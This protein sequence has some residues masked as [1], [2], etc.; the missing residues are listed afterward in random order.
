LNAKLADSKIFIVGSGAIGCELLKNLAMMGVG[1]SSTGSIHITDMDRIEK[2]NLNRQFL[3]GYQDIGKYKS[4]AVVGAI[5]RINPGVNIIAQQNK[6]GHETLSIYNEK[7]MRELTCVLTALDNIQARIFV[8]NLCIDSTIPLIDSGTLGTKGNVQTIIPHMTQTYGSTNDPAEQ[9]IPLC[10][11]KSFPYMIEHTIQ[12][13]RDL[14]EGLYIKAP[15]NYMRYV[16]SPQSIKSINPSELKEVIDDIIFVSENL[17]C[18]V[19]ECVE[20]AYKMWHVHFRDLIYH[21]VQKFPQDMVNEFGVKYW[22]GTKKCPEQPVFSLKNALH[23]NFVIACSN[24]WAKVFGLTGIIT[25]KLIHKVLKNVKIPAI[26]PLKGDIKVEEP[27]DGST[28]VGSTTVD[29]TTVGSTDQDLIQQLPAVEEIE[30]HPLEF[31]KDDD[32]NHHIDFITHSSNMR[33]INYGIPIADKFKTKGIAGKIIPAL[34]TTTSLVSGLVAVELLKIVQ[35]Y[36]PDANVDVN[37]LLE[38]F[39]NSYTN[40]ALPFFGFTEPGAVTMD[41]V[42]KYKFSLWDALIM[43]NNPKLKSIIA[44]V[45]KQIDDPSVEISQI[46]SGKYSLYMNGFGKNKRMDM[47]TAEILRAIDPDQEIHFPVKLTFFFDKDELDLEPV[48]CRIYQ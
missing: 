31:E 33:A 32:T 20:F 38:R 36:T 41:S 48:V 22:S 1:T 13:A 25:E 45:R 17:V 10:T 5:S 8:D 21:L 3:F 24:L 39:T 16:K 4:E 23:L 11:L 34:A 46:T 47:T 28:T 7:F 30:V 15:Q 29:S 27:K 6:V 14:F 37:T 9:S 43:K 12:W 2:S 19:N 26:T 18:H 42:G 35:G 40:L 44:H